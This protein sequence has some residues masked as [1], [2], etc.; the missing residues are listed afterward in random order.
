MT[1]ETLRSVLQPSAVWHSPE[2]F[3]EQL[4][5]ERDTKRCHGVIQSRTGSA[6]QWERRNTHCKCRLWS[7]GSSAHPLC[8]S[9]LQRP[10]PGTE[11]E[12]RP[13]GRWAC[14]VCAREP[15]EGCM[16][17]C[18]S[19]GMTLRQHQA[20]QLG[21]WPGGTAAVCSAP[22]ERA[23]GPCA[24]PNRLQI[25]PTAKPVPVSPPEFLF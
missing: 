17:I 3:P 23:G 2:T 8:T 11:L 21:F 20:G 13:R 4:R 19:W 22:G 7:W 9:S 16:Q 14:G 1:K 6:S 24:M 18:R 15:G 10:Q 25:P 5:P 12:S